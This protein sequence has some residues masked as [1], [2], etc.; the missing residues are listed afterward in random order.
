MVVCL[1][2]WTCSGGKERLPERGGKNKNRDWGIFPLLS[3][4]QSHSLYF[5]QFLTSFPE[6]GENDKIGQEFF[7]FLFSFFFFLLLANAWM[8]LPHLDQE[9]S[10]THTHTHRERKRE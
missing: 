2:V 7:F 8:V 3:S 10:Y 5:V 6:V 4:Q 1:L 9:R